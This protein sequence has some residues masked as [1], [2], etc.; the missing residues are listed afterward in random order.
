MIVRIE[1]K[2]SSRLVSRKRR[3]KIWNVICFIFLVLLAVM[4]MFPIYWIFRSS[5]MSN[6]ELYAY[7]PSF[8]PPA[9]R[10]ENYSS[11]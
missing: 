3:E 2:Y 4:V 10:W 11:V 7:P 6:A 9:W 1:K 8:T 5:L